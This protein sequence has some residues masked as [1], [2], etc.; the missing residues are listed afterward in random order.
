MFEIFS[1]ALYIIYK[2]SYVSLSVLTYNLAE[3]LLTTHNAFLEVTINSKFIYILL[4][5]TAY[6]FIYII[7]TLLS[8]VKLSSVEKYETQLKAHYEEF[9]TIDVAQK[10]I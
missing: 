4:C 9:L 2:H 7:L 10:N 3:K 5:P 1:A 6:G 8:I